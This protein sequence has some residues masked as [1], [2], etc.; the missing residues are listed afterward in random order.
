MI[1]SVLTV[2]HPDGSETVE[3]VFKTTTLALDYYKRNFHPRIYSFII[4]ELEV[5]E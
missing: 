1:V 4:Q 5:K 2:M 3:G